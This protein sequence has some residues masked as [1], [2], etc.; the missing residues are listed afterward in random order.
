MRA[1]ERS[2]HS[3]L[4]HHCTILFLSDNLSIVLCFNRGRSHFRLLT[5][6]RRF[7]SVCLARNI[8]IS[9]W[10]I[11]SEFNRSDRVSREHDSK[12]LVDHLSSNDGQTFPVSHA[13][14]SREPGSFEYKAFAASDGVA[15]ERNLFPDALSG[16]AEEMENGWRREP[17]ARKDP[18]SSR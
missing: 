16:V 17:R 10:W 12:S 1:A 18:T 6:I 4:V 13:W 15:T 2:T 14:L 8:K 7:A 9:I 5:Q 11:P 3:H